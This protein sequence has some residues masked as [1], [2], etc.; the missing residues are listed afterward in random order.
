MGT[1]PDITMSPD[2]V[3]AFLAT[4]TRAVVVALADGVPVGS[5]GALALVGPDEG[6]DAIDTVEAVGVTR[7][8]TRCPEA[9]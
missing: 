3:R 7:T 6:V 4:Q 2:E 9:M 5:V 1:R 8:T